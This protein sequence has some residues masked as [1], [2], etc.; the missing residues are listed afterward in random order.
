MRIDP[1]ATP[2]AT[3]VR[4]SE[5]Q[6]GGAPFVDMESGEG[7]ALE[8]LCRADPVFAQRYEGWEELGRG[9]GACVVRTYQRDL[10]QDVA[11]KVALHLRP[12]ERRRLASEAQSLMRCGHPCV[13]HVLGTFS[14]GVVSWLELEYVEGETLDAELGRLR[15]LRARMPWRAGLEIAAC[16][17]EGLAAVHAA[18]VVHC[19]VKP[20]N[21]LLPRGGH[22]AAKLADF[23]IAR[24]VDATIVIEEGVP[25]TPRYVSPEALQRGVRVGPAGDVYALALTLYQV[26]SGGLYPF[27]LRD[28]PTLGEMLDC[29]AHRA[30]LPLRLLAPEVPDEVVDAIHQGLHKKPSRRPTAVEIGRVMRDVQARTRPAWASGWEAE[31]RLRRHDRLASWVK[32]LGWLALGLAAASGGWLLWSEL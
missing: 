18:G 8:R 19:D 9:A 29:H 20:S 6:A 16:L 21:V 15:E 14:R 4:W 30:P 5:P 1:D 17:A 12:E 22:P 10:G 3:D 27:A 32:G 13:V 31:Q 23:G 2:R 26:F 25:G 7:D 28:E 11:L 24:S